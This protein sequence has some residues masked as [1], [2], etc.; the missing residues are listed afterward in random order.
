M[1]SYIKKAMSYFHAKPITFWPSRDTI[2]LYFLL[3]W[4]RRTIFVLPFQHRQSLFFVFLCPLRILSFH[5]ELLFGKIASLMRPNLSLVD[6]NNAR[7][8]LIEMV[9]A[10]FVHAPTF[11]VS[12]TGQLGILL[13]A[14]LALKVEIGAHERIHVEVGQRGRIVEVFTRSRLL[15]TATYTA[16]KHL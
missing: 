7:F 12:Q 5:V 14:R 2:F 8:E 3:V 15:F 6:S 4:H 13:H 16:K 1:S 9:H 11:E 10:L